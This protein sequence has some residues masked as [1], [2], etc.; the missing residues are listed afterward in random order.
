MTVVHIIQDK[1]WRRR[2]VEAV[3]SDGDS[4]VKRDDEIIPFESDIKTVIPHF[5]DK[6][7]YGKSLRR[8][9]SSF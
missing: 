3:I 8:V 9:P 1:R 7:I 2:V 4:S 5:T 6:E